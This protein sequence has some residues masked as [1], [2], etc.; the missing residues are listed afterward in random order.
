VILL[1][2]LA[3][4]GDRRSTTETLPKA[5]VNSAVKLI[6]RKQ[7]RRTVPTVTRVNQR[8]SPTYTTAVM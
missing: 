5:A 3:L 4:V 6:T 8:S 1:A 7:D 2:G